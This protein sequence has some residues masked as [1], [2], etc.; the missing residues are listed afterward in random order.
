MEAMAQFPQCQAVIPD[1]QNSSKTD[2]TIEQVLQRFQN[3]DH[4]L[5]RRQL[6]AVRFYL[7]SM[8][9]RCQEEW[10]PETRSGTNY[11][12]LLSQIELTRAPEAQVCLVTFNYDTMLEDAISSTLRLRI[13]GLADYIDGQY[14][15]VLKLHGSVN[16]ARQVHT[17]SYGNA[18]GQ[19]LAWEL[20]DQ[21]DQ[22]QFTRHY[23]IPKGQ[24]EKSGNTA[25][26]PAIAIPVERKDTY[27]CPYD[28][29]KALE[30]CVAQVSNL[31]LIGWRAT[32]E[33]FLGLLRES[34]PSVRAHVVAG[35][36]EEVDEILDRLRRAG[37]RAELHGA[38]AEGFTHFT[39]HKRLRDFLSGQ[40]PNQTVR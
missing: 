23:S 31:L 5:R 4:P 35:T 19:G 1:L 25:D 20:I 10:N 14:Y 32:E 34:L 30:S 17:P 7:Q 33:H 3:E 21:I 6:A 16:W 27:E 29:V 40:A 37:V 11:Q 12:A 8:I 2:E 28:H 18:Y 24:I 38:T 26:F 9:S 39:Q 13:Q 22:L 36:M 15:K